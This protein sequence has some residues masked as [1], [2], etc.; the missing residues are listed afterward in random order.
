MID[1]SQEQIAELI[2]RSLL[3]GAVLGVIYDFIRALKMLCGIELYEGG[4]RKKAKG[5]AFWGHI[6]TFFADLI[7]WVGAGCSAILLMYWS[8]GYFRGVTFVCTAV[9]FLAYYF[10]LGILVLKI[11][12]G[13]V[14]RARRFFAWVMPY[15]L[16]PIKLL[17]N[18][19][20]LLYHLTI[21]RIIDKIIEERKKEQ[22]KEECDEQAGSDSCD[23]EGGKE[24]FVYVGEKNGYRRDGRVSFGRRSR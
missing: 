1:V 5:S 19:I 14:I 20:I 16:K 13:I 7:F 21:G 15:A 17:L 6:F 4:R 8:G 2:F 9:G 11:N 23:L 3:C 22:Q 12:R 10:T 18:R 24:G